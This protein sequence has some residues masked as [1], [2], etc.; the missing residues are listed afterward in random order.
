MLTDDDNLMLLT[1][2]GTLMLL[3]DDDS[4]ML[5]TDDDTFDQLSFD[6]LSIV[7]LLFTD[8]ETKSIVFWSRFF[9]SSLLECR[10]IIE[11]LAEGFIMT[12]PIF[13]LG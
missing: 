11:V 9:K 8:C 13:F 12:S 7:H 10:D 2:D 6:Y 3:S 1:D 5:Q 4:L